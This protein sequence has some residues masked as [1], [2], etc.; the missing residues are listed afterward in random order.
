M[1][2]Q[3]GATEAG[4]PAAVAKAFVMALE[5]RKGAHWTPTMLPNRGYVVVNGCIPQ[6]CIL[7]SGAI[8]FVIN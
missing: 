1:W 7:N 5:M 6:M 4:A 2:T 8:T 3:S